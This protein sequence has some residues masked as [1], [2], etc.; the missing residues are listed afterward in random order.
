MLRELTIHNF[1]TI[2]NL[3]VEFGEGLNI[4]T[5]ETGSGKSIVVD[6]LNLALGGRADS[7]SI[8]TGKNT[9]SVEAVFEIDNQNISNQIKSLGITIEDGQLIVKRTLSIT[10]KHRAHLNGSSVT[11]GILSEVGDQL[12]DIH[13]QH[14]HQTLLRP[15][16]HIDLLDSYGRLLADRNRYEKEYANYQKTSTELDHLKKNERN[17]FQREDLLKFQVGEIDA[18][19]LSESEEDC[20]KNE[21]NR[22]ANAE[23]IKHGLTKVVTVLSDN[24]GSASD[25]LGIIN[26]ELVRLQ[27]YDEE[28]K[29]RAE[30]AQ[31]IFYEVEDLVSGLRD[32]I[33]S[34]E[35][36]PTRLAEIEDRLAEMNGLKRKYNCNGIA[37][38][39]AYRKSADAELKTLSVNQERLDALKKELDLHEKRLCQLAEDLAKKREQNALELSKK[40]AS[41]LKDLNMNQA[42]LDIRFIYEPGGF[43]LFRGKYAKLG[44]KGIGAM[45][46]LFTANPGEEPRPLAKIA[47][48][49]ELARVMLALKTL[50]NEQDR[51]ESL[52]FDEV[53][54]G[55]GGS[56]AEKIGRKLKVLSAS[57]Q[58]FCITHLPQIAGM[59]VAHYLLEKKT[60]A[61]RT[62]TVIR[63]L[64]DEERIEEL[65]RMSGGTK[66]TDATRKH[67]KEMLRT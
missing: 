63:K 5:G 4:L 1:A 32:C 48:G 53:D 34:G 16:L 22:L 65:A 9:A 31:S 60:S 26:Q 3:S 6:A 55:V 12:V 2:E 37:D 35:F 25:C 50:L 24:E 17:R 45:E 49:G 11:V 33:R 46:F 42:R 66:I 29:K 15:E 36:D 67:A 43:V 41:E 10:G 14:D 52:V 7:D 38:V 58:V 23:K 13:G 40:A 21:R 19:C 64:R 20:L 39:L 47:S 59:G 30:Q 28:L 54:T 44:P 56:V 61:G 62:R 8:R 18:A 51:I 27:D 57:K